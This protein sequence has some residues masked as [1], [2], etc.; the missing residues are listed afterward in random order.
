MENQ[1]LLSAGRLLSEEGNLAEAGYAFDLVKTYSRSDIKAPRSRIKEWDYYYVGNVNYGVALTVADNGYMSL[2]SISVLEFGEHPFDATRSIAGLFPMGKLHLPAS[3]QQGDIHFQG[4]GFDILFT[5]QN[6]KR[7]LV[8]SMD[9]LGK[10][11]ERFSC[12]ILLEPT[13]DKS[14]VIAT[15]FKKKGHFYYNQK[16]NNLRA[17]GYAKLGDKVYDFNQNSYGVLDW[18][19]GVWTYKNTWFWSSLNTE[20]NGHPFGWNLG[21]GFGD[22]SA[23]SENMLFV[24]GEALKLKDVIMDIPLT[25]SGRDDFLSS[26]R[27][28]DKEGAIWVDFKPVYDRHAD[29]NALVLRSNQHQV[30]GLFSGRIDAGGKSYSF[31]NLPGFAEKVFNKW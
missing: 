22:T 15:P 6:G 19:R 28:R 30:F 23:A 12:D 10:K 17:S 14:M 27:L 16:I 13:S 2:A 26:W 21:Y 8:A 4:K 29:V 5:L 7:H 11:K 9:K 31:K 3:S 18:G 25:S 24:D 20:I 1:H